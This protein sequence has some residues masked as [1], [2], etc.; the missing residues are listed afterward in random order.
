ME[1]K[2]FRNSVFG[3]FN[4]DDVLHYIEE[5]SRTCRE[6][7]DADQKEIAAL[8][9][10][11]RA[12]LQEIETLRSE[13]EALRRQ[14]E[15]QSGDEVGQASLSEQL[16][17]LTAERD[18][19]ARQLAEAN[20]KL[21]ELEPASRSYQALQGRLSGIELDAH[22]RAAAIEAAAVS[23]AE[24]LK[25]ELL[26]AALEARTAYENVWTNSD[27]AYATFRRELQDLTGVFERL[28][29][30]FDTVS[31]RLEDIR[32]AAESNRPILPLEE[33]S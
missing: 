7:S 16:E 1:N 21:A 30:Y 4:R 12:L 5:A 18:A 32:V 24:A 22:T 9:E 28:G 3:G 11:K 2:R 27:G 31:D 20:E 26:S 19:L 33:E 14:T 10:E 23:H 8:D 13:N 6:R 29:A 15:E 25:Q 17:A